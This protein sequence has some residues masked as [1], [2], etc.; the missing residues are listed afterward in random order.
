M[1]K[2]RGFPISHLSCPLHLSLAGPGDAR[3]PSS[4]GIRPW[5]IEKF[6][7]SLSPLLSPWLYT[8]MH[9]KFCALCSLSV[10]GLAEWARGLKKC[11][12]A[13]SLSVSVQLLRSAD[14][15]FQVPTRV[16]PPPHVLSLYPMKTTKRNGPLF[17]QHTGLTSGHVLVYVCPGQLGLCQRALDGQEQ[18]EE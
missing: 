12:W 15:P 1:R 18:E 5:K 6:P 3:R 7:L 16:S 13:D 4:R 10:Q 14:P 17:V 11:P 8:H 9:N 2:R